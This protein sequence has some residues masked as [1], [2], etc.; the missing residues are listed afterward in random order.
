MRGGYHLHTDQ[1]AGTSG[2][3]AGE[4]LRHAGQPIEL[5]TGGSGMGGYN[6]PAAP[7]GQN[8]NGAIAGAI[9]GAPHVGVIGLVLI[10]VAILIILDQL[11]F[12][13]AVTAGKR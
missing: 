7:A 6:G 4:R 13:F 5:L 10:A 2:E 9:S 12:R 8:A 1:L 11:G 3:L